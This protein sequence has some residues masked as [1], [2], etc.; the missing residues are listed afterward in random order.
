MFAHKRTLIVSV[1][2]A[3]SALA[4]VTTPLALADDHGRGDKGDGGKQAQV[5]S[6]TDRSTQP[7]VQ[8]DVDRGTQAQVQTDADTAQA[9][10]TNAADVRLDNLL[11]AISNDV[12]NLSSLNVNQDDPDDAA[13]VKAVRTI[14]L[15][16][17]ESGLSA[18][19]AAQITNAVNANTSALQT[20]LN[21][22]TAQATA[23]DNSLTAAGV[24]P[25]SA[26]AVFDLRDGRLIV[27]TA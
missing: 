8:T 11:A 6:D 14:S 18:T 13:N 21:G 23:I 15:A 24:S 1:L 26:L 20:F 25:S 7:Q 16:S 22:G 5:Q 4:L 9:A 3:L 2:T 17:L 19:D 10:A 12:T 27:I